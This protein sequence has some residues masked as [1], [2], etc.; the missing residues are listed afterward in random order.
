MKKILSYLI[1]IAITYTIAAFIHNP[2]LKNKLNTFIKRTPQEVIIKNMYIKPKIVYV[3]K[4]PL[5]KAEI[6]GTL[7]RNTEVGLITIQDKWAKVKTPAGI[8]GWVLLDS[9]KEQ[10][11]QTTTK[12]EEPKQEI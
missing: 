4:E 1:V 9:L 11:P 10:P 12:K 2:D 7:K 8:S 6:L 5:D 3:R